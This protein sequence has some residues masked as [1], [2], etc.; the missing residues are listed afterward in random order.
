MKPAILVIDM[1]NDFILEGAPLECGR[2]REIIKPIKRLID[3]G[4]KKNIPIIYITDG[5]DPDD[6]EFKI[7]PPHAVENTKGA[8]VIDALKPQ[9]GEI[10]V[11]KKTYDGFFRTNLEKVLKEKK[12]DTLI[13][14]GVCTDICILHTGSSATLLGY[15]VKVP[16]E[17]VAALTDEDH[18][19]ALKH[20]E[21]V[22]KSNV[23]S[24]DKII[25]Q[26]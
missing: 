24:L 15:D 13:L 10:I 21:K 22:L 12:I 7:W 1:L 17:C 18:N 11:K 6:R 20:L 19:F 8:E 9:K 3:Y 23:D 14:T 25:K 2:G 4:R 5:H 16:K 26:L